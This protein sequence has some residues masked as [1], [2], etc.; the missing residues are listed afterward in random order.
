MG[1]QWREPQ[2]ASVDADVIDLDTAFGGQF[3]DVPIGQAVSQAPAHRQDDD[4]GRIPET[5]EG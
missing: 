5:R 2:D 3:V 1:R 4:L